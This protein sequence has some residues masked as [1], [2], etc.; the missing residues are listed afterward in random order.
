MQSMQI[1]LNYQERFKEVYEVE[2]S[3]TVLALKQ[4]I[5]ALIG[6]PTHQFWLSSETQILE[7]EWTFEAAGIADGE[8][9]YV[10][11]I[12]DRVVPVYQPEPAYHP[13]GGEDALRQAGIALEADLA[14]LQQLA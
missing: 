12:I 5:S 10:E 8:E 6:I 2:P 4:R 7:N 3:S 14:K 13:A 11:G 9:L 1:R